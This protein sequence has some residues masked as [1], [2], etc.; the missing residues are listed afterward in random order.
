[1]QLVILP[2]EGE[3]EWPPLSGRP[4][5]FIV[6]GSRI[7]TRMRSSASE[8]AEHTLGPN[9]QTPG[10]NAEIDFIKSLFKIPRASKTAN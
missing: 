9:R 6:F 7:Q 10:M 1:M 5:P 3:K 4:C 2:W 8:L